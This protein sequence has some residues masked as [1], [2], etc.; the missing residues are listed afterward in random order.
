MGLEGRV[1]QRGEVQ[2]ERMWD[3]R[4]AIIVILGKINKYPPNL[5]GLQPPKFISHICCMSR[6]GHS[7]FCFSSVFILGVY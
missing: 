3:I 1:G 6:V 2:I 7:Q 4:S 5:S